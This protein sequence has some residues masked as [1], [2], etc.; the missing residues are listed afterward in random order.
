MG[1]SRTPCR[2]HTYNTLQYGAMITPD[3]PKSPE[4]D[5]A[6]KLIICRKHLNNQITYQNNESTMTCG[7]LE[8]HYCAQC[9]DP[10][11]LSF[12]T[13]DVV[14]LK[15]KTYTRMTVPEGDSM[16]MIMAERLETAP[17]LTQLQAPCKL[18]KR[19][20]EIATLII[21]AQPNSRIIETLVISKSTLK[22]HLNNIY[23]KA[24]ELKLFREGLQ[25]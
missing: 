17:N 11:D 9:P 16:V 7:A 2:N 13:T 8:G 14:Q 21:A 22:T 5:S 15:N 25:L 3:N 12:P 19:E 10:K 23:R 4:T 18:S 6:P 20:L 1:I 24:P